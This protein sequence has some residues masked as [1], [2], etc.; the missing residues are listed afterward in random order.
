M[1]VNASFGIAV[2]EINTR[3]VHGHNIGSGKQKQDNKQAHEP[4]PALRETC[5]NTSLK[6]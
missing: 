6:T 4:D 1:F 5:S 3:P 2:T